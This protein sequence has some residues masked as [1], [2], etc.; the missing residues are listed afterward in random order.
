[1]ATLYK[2]IKLKN[3]Q[4]QNISSLSAHNTLLQNVAA[5]VSNKIL[6]AV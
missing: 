2:V 1:M 4:T 3:C 5:V 6:L